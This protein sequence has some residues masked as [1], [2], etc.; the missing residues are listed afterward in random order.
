MNGSLKI[1]RNRKAFYSRSWSQLLCGVCKLIHLG[2]KT[3]FLRP[4]K[5]NLILAILY[6]FLGGGGAG[7]LLEGCP[8]YT[9]TNHHPESPLGFSASGPPCGRFSTVAIAAR[10]NFKGNPLRDLEACRGQTILSTEGNNH[11]NWLICTVCFLQ[12]IETCWNHQTCTEES[13]SLNK[14]VM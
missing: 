4:V 11:Q 1:K 7:N 9:S 6:F 2:K 14:L 13:C 10:G 8:K 12:F 3:D 5:A